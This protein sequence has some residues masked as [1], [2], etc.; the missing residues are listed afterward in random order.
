MTDRLLGWMAGPMA[1]AGIDPVEA[2]RLITLDDRDGFLAMFGLRQAVSR[3]YAVDG[4]IATISL[5]GMIHPG[6]TSWFGTGCTTLMEQLV[7]AR[8]DAAV[9]GVLVDVSSPGGIPLKLTE[10][11][12]LMREISAVKPVHVHATTA[13]S[14]SLWI[15]VGAARFTADELAPIGSIGVLRTVNLEMMDKYMFIT[16]SNAANKRPD[17]RTEE[18]RATE[19]RVADAIEARF[20]A[21]LSDHRGITAEQII[22]GF[23]HGSV[24]LGRDAVATGMIDAVSTRAEAMAR[25]RAEA[26]LTA[27]ALPTGGAAGHA[28]AASPP[29]QT[30]NTMSEESTAGGTASVSPENLTLAQLA[31]ANPGL[32]AE[33]RAEATKQESER[34]SGIF[35]LAEGSAHD[36]SALL[37]ELA[38]DPSVSVADATARVLQA[39]RA[40]GKD[41]VAN[42]KQ[43]EADL[44]EIEAGNPNPDGG[45]VNQPVVFNP[46]DPEA[47]AK[48]FAEANPEIV[49]EFASY[50]GFEAMY[51][52]ME[53]K[54]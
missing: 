43:A 49:A 54:I 16:S 34:V 45:T 32:L 12:D 14:G 40:A 44:P 27:A 6:E 39:E 50:A 53:G 42:R 25:L 29:P 24:L 41:W 5:R 31:S 15:A 3:D 20:L 18:G 36:H 48:A 10:T 1:L 35:A 13:T 4:G 2:Y 26:G 37:T 21:C 51:I 23:D 7:K 8:D 11:A 30:E 9:K 17:P 19:L 46:S 33:I 47:S 52:K 22:T 38:G 28:A